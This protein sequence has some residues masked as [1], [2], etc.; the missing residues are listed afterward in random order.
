MYLADI[1]LLIMSWHKLAVML[2]MRFCSSKT[3]LNLQSGRSGGTA[4]FALRMHASM[5]NCLAT[6]ADHPVY[7][8]APS[9]TPQLSTCCQASRQAG[10][11]AQEGVDAKKSGT[12][13]E[14][15]NVFLLAQWKHGASSILILIIYLANLQLWFHKG[16]VTWAS[17]LLDGIRNGGQRLVLHW[18][19]ALVNRWLRPFRHMRGHRIFLCE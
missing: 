19:L 5:L 16:S 8:M 14:E 10:A 12:L 4:T 13:L 11:A 17:I 3:F 15:E 18:Q 1:A 9:D 6:L 2:G 7:W